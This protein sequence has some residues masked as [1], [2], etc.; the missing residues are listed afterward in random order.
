[1]CDA[2]N[3]LIHKQT[4]SR[5]L[6]AHK[7]VLATTAIPPPQIEYMPAGAAAVSSSASASASA[8]AAASSSSASAS[9][10]FVE[11]ERPATMPTLNVTHAMSELDSLAQVHKM[12]SS[13]SRLRLRLRRRLLLHL[14]LL[15]PCVESCF[16][17][18]RFPHLLFL[19]FLFILIFSRPLTCTFPL[20][21]ES[22]FLSFTSSH[23]YSLL[24]HFSSG[25]DLCLCDR[26]RAAAASQAR[27]LHLFDRPHSRRWRRGAGRTRERRRGR[28]L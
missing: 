15:Q 14:F 9:L 4:Q 6:A 13:L 19:F 18:F 3:A 23:S 7:L 17:Y 12:S 26:I 8:A 10:R 25:D 20:A 16:V 11:S 27:R 21:F 5:L 2:C 28:G 22:G 1:V 24:H